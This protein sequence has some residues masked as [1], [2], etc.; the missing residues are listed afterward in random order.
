MN[1]AYSLED[2]QSLHDEFPGITDKKLLKQILEEKKIERKEKQKY[3]R[4]KK[5]R[6]MLVS[7]CIFYTV[8]S[9]VILFL[10]I[11][12]PLIYYYNNKLNYEK[13]A[14]EIEVEICEIKYH[15]EYKTCPGHCYYILPNNQ[16]VLEENI[17][18]IVGLANFVNK[19]DFVIMKAL[20]N[21]E[22]NRYSKLKYLRLKRDK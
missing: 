21:K 6:K 11:G 19:G 5:E 7:Q 10:I 17:K 12:V 3:L 14:I 16:T 13:N 18:N 1:E 20:Y 2:I 22:E 8:G 4:R 15:Q 9:L